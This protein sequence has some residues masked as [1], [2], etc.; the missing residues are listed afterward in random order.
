M[1]VVLT[2]F[3]KCFS[4]MH[5][6]GIAGWTSISVARW[7]PKNM[8]MQVIQPFA[9]QAY[10]RKLTG[11]HSVDEYYE[12]YMNTLLSR[13]QEVMRHIENLIQNFGNSTPVLCCWCTIEQQRRK[14]YNTIMCHTIPLAWILRQHG[15]E[16]LFDDDR[17][18]YGIDYD[19]VIKT[20]YNSA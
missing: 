12:L 10:G 11:F 19:D 8:N 1:K 16:P 9:P 5:K 4:T 14:G 15:L 6:L 7:M 3:S 17:I 13:R 18:Q 2:S 20:S